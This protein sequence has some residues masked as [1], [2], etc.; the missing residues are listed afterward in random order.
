MFSNIKRDYDYGI[1]SE[2][3]I[4][5][6]LQNLW[7]SDL[8]CSPDKFATIDF[9]SNTHLV[10]LK[11][12]R[13]SFNKYPTTMIGKNKIDYLVN[14]EKKGIVVFKFTDGLYYLEITKDNI[15]KFGLEEGGRRD[16][17]YDERQLYYFIPTKMLKSIS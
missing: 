4:L 15:N 12:R 17:G 16:R 10:E 7:G 1:N 14:S 6:T 9:S 5:P 11:T 3:S 8:E 13:N 2:C